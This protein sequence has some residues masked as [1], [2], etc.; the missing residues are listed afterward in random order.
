MDDPVQKAIARFGLT[1]TAIQP[2]A[3]SYSSTVRI[4]TLA[5][6]E[7]VVLK[8]P[9]SL[10]K[11]RREVYMLNLVR[12]HVTVPTVLDHYLEAE[13]GAL[14]LNL[15]PGQSLT[16]NVT[17]DL[18]LQM[19][20]LLAQLHC[21]PMT[22]F[23][24]E[25]E[26]QPA[27]ALGW[28]A[29]A[30]AQ[31][32][33]WAPACATILEP[34]LIQRVE[35]LYQQLWTQLPPPDGPCAVHYDY[36]PANVLAQDG[37]VTG[38]IDFESAHGGSAE[39]DFSKIQSEVWALNPATKAPFLAGYGRV[40]PLPDLEHTLAYHAL[41]NAFGGVAWCLRRGALRHDPFMEYN[42]NALERLTQDMH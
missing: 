35:K 22:V 36:R 21:K 39:R 5:S 17:P 34:E 11:L 20:E 30:D 8:I 6:G 27:P 42:I 15:L 29:S 12:D 4:L 14:L 40:R 10:S 31:F 25:F 2:V 16:A 38:L 28:W 23:G 19:G 9:F 7:Q 26:T 37:V 32:Q 1:V 24:D 33:H 41:H 3:E 18:A 13:S